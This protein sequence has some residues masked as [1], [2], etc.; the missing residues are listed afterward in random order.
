MIENKK[1]LIVG[2]SYLQLPA[3]IK[4]KEMGL[5]VAVADYNSNAIGASYADKYYN[6]STIDE[7]GIYEAAKEF[8]ADGVITLATDMPM[9]AVAYACEQLGL[10]GISY[11]TAIKSTDKGEMIKAFES[12]GVKHPWYFI[13]EDIEQL[14]RF[15]SKIMY[16]CISKPIDSS[17]SRGVVL[18]DSP[19]KLRESIFYSS[20]HG[21]KKGVIIEEYMRGNEVS[22]E[23]VVINDVV[24]VL[25]ITDKLTTGAPH[26]VEMRHNQPSRLGDK[27]V[28]R[29]KELAEKAVLAV[30][31]KNGPAHVEIMLTE[32]GPKII[33]LGARM[34][35]DFISTHL[36]QLSTGI[37]MVKA[38]IS[39]ACGE[40]VDL[41][42]KF[43]RGSSIQYITGDAGYIKS[44]DGIDLASKIDGVVEVT[45]LKNVGEQSKEVCNSLDRLGYVIAQ[46]SSVL[47]AMNACEQAIA[48][49]KLEIEESKL[50][51]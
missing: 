11:D 22:V 41:D 42:P 8:C 24:H 17:G 26:F 51:I 30:G 28:E 47:D 16:P 43:N 18:I 45:M 25:A 6:I 33:E 1:L 50:R 34:G 27:N 20:T 19:E 29:I 36:V 12:H 49:I 14:N 10:N 3:I 15:D 21:R 37:D 35:G 44:I 9:R 40:V 5:Q 13:L 38:V 31:I 4:A 39:L 23:I 32:E 7:K 2:G 46:G 48:C